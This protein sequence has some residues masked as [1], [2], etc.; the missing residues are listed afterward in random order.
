MQITWHGSSCFSIG[1][2]T[3]TLVTDPGSA[4]L[5]ADVAVLSDPA[6][7]PLAEQL[8][9]VGQ[10]I[11]WPGEYEV[12]DV[13]IIGQATTAPRTIYSI[14]AEGMTLCH[15]AGALDKLTVEQV[16]HLGDVDVL[17]LPS[18]AG[19]LD[20]AV[21]KVVLEQIDPRVVIPMGDDAEATQKLLTLI[22]QEPER[23]EGALKLERRDLPEDTMRL[24]VLAPQPV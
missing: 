20:P 15:L 13:F 4:K 9:G 23:P 11:D 17:L 16:E 1:T 24:I 2:K 5:K 7:R 3:A 22:G 18:G 6:L 10:V 12:R 14:E 19:S 8:G 21:A